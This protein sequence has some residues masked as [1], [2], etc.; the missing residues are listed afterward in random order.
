MD[1]RFTVL[2][3][4]ERP[5]FPA[6][7]GVMT[8]LVEVAPGSGGSPPHRHSGP[9]FGYVLEGEVIFE[10]EG[11]APRVLRAGDTFSEPGGDVVHYRAANNRPDAWA[12][13]LAVMVCAPGVEML[14]YLTADEIA[15]RRHLRHP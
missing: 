3:D 13:F 15:A 4:V 14:T 5:D 6:D 9:V 1:D 10:L 12:R 2:A 11:E 8:A 7:A